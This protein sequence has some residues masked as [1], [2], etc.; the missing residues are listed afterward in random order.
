MVCAS[1]QHLR[2]LK[3]LGEVHLMQYLGKDIY[4][5]L[6]LQMKPMH[7]AYPFL[8]KTEKIHIACRNKLAYVGFLARHLDP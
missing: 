3:E 8:K 5:W 4:K 2:D 1:R 7:H 6:L